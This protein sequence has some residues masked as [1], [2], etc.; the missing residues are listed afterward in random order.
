MKGVR[1]IAFLVMFIYK[2][3]YSCVGVSSVKHRDGVAQLLARLTVSMPKEPA[4]WHSYAILLLAGICLTTSF[5][6]IYFVNVGCLVGFG[7]GV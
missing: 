3:C 6:I 2:F 4:P 5:I 7:S 1:R